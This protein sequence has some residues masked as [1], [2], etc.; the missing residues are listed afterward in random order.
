MIHN[1]VEKEKTEGTKAQDQIIHDIKLDE[2]M[3]KWP[4]PNLCP[5]RAS[6]ALG[7]E[8]QGYYPIPRTLP[9][10]RRQTGWRKPRGCP[11]WK[12]IIL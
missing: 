5:T 2:S 3:I 7:T 9:A 1:D 11:P 6:E 10:S 4:V 12:A 8:S